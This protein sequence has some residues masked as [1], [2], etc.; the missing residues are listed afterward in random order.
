MPHDVLR[1]VSGEMSAIEAPDIRY[2]GAKSMV[3]APADNVYNGYLV[4]GD[5][6]ADVRGLDFSNIPVTLYK[7]GA[8]A[9]TSTSAA[10]MGNPVSVV[11]WL[12]NQL[13]TYGECL[14][15]G[16][17][18]ITGSLNP[19]V[20]IEVGDRFPADFGPLGRVQANCV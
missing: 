12:A 5:T 6:M 14:E 11:A 10:A 7:N 4:V 8:V 20:Y 15:K 2:S 16:D 18:V 1:R 17:N 3:D 19:A 13:P 9:N